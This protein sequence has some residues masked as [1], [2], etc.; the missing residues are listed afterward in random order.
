[1]YSYMLS[2]NDAF[3]QFDSIRSGRLVFGQFQAMVTRLCQLAGDNVPAFNVIKDLFDYIDI[4]KDGV[5]D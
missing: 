1:M 2:P 4:R 3:W 5:I